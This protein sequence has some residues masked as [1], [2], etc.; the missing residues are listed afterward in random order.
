[1][2]DILY[3]PF[4]SLFWWIVPY[5]YSVP[6]A[7]IS[8]KKE[9]IE[10]SRSLIHAVITVIWL[11]LIPADKY[12]DD[13]YSLFISM[14]AKVSQSYFMFDIIISNSNL[15]NFHHVISIIAAQGAVS[16]PCYS[17]IILTTFLA[18]ELSNVVSHTDRLLQMCSIDHFQ[19]FNIGIYIFIRN[20][21][22]LYYYGYI[23]IL[24]IALEQN[25]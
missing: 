17:E 14:W 8:K 6:D 23:I 2:S 13:D 18:S 19:L 10:Y 15:L 20:I 9:F 21:F 24:G 5:I 25:I 22:G 1:M 3:L 4:I 16:Y 7:A 12:M 11:G